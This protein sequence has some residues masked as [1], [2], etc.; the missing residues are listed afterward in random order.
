M[1]SSRSEGAN[2]WSARLPL[3]F[4]QRDSHP[5]TDGS[6]GSGPRF[7]NIPIALAQ[8][9]SDLEAA[10]TKTLLI[11]ANPGQVNLVSPGEIAPALKAG[12]DRAVKAADR[13]KAF[14]A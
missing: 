6:R 7:S 12:Y 10:K 11:A 2:S 5:L 9:L 8:E 4:F 13:V 1:S 14:W 3:C